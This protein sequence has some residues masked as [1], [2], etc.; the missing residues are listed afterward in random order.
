MD[1]IFKVLF[2]FKF[3]YIF[4]GRGFELW[5]CDAEDSG[6]VIY[7]FGL[8]SILSFCWDTHEGTAK[9]P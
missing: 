7:S 5:I 4:D 3:S 8:L 1:K 2:D 9:Y 6:I